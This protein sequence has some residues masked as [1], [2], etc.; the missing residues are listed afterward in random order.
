[1]TI[2]CSGAGVTVGQYTQKCCHDSW[3]LCMHSIHQYRGISVMVHHVSRG[4]ENV[5]LLKQGHLVILGVPK[6]PQFKFPKAQNL[7]GNM[8]QG[9]L[10]AIIVRS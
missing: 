8:L 10:D 2:A 7:S 5:I 3:D 9:I 4:S 1:M 6:S